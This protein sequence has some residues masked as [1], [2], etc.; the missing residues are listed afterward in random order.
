[1][2]KLV[3]NPNKVKRN[4]RFEIKV[5]G[6]TLA[7]PQKISGVVNMKNL[8]DNPR[9]KGIAKLYRVR[10]EGQHDLHGREIVAYS[11]EMAALTFA[12]DLSVPIP[13][14]VIVRD[15]DNPYHEEDE[16]R[17]RCSGRLIV[18]DLLI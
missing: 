14:R 12:K 10:S 17:L 15:M 11:S 8:A 4:F 18:A 1:M 7:G 5:D 6:F 13:S 16:F 3:D 9:G 2:R